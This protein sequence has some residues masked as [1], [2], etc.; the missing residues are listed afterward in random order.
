M[1]SD[2]AKEGLIPIYNDSCNLYQQL[3]CCHHYVFLLESA[4]LDH[5]GHSIRLTCIYM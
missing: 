3:L 1:I 2:E 5:D 4:D